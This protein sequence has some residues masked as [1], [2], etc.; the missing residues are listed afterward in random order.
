[1]RAWD[2]VL[3][4][5]GEIGIKSAPVRRSMLERLRRNLLTGME[6]AKVEG[7]VATIGARLW[8]VGPDAAALAGV[9]QRTFGVVSASPARLVRSDLPALC[10]AAAALALTRTWRTFA[11]R[12][13]REG[14]HPY[15]SQ[16]V[17][18][19]A[20]SAVY[21][22]AEA[23]G[24][25]PKVDLTKPEFE[26]HVDVRQDKAWLFTDHVQGP[27][28]LPVG[29]QGRVLA[30]LSDEASF[31]AAWLMLR[32]GCDVAGLHAGDTGSVPIDAVAELEKWGMDTEVELL[33]VC[34]GAVTKE[35]LLAAAANV[36]R[37][38]K[39]A[40]LVTGETLDSVFAASPM[41]VLRPVCGLL[42]A[43][44]VRWRARAA[45]APFEPVRLLQARSRETVDSLLAMRRTVTL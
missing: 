17:G 37:D 26:V 3:V 29:C 13:S 32:R 12:A 27:G 45:F 41:P 2:G 35:T 11:I 8:M 40:A 18:I 23:A 9:A 21:K 1:V 5:F 31:V 30:L 10:D 33:P 16:D 42:P 19:Q 43:E 28:G 6:M 38:R 14:T 25:R 44:Y 20:G 15:T 22:A 7:D 36:A 34:S 24:R 4:R 39:C